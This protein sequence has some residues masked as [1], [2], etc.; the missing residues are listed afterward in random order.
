MKHIQ[1]SYSS[2]DKQK[3]RV[4]IS[5]I[6]LLVL[7]ILLVFWNINAGSVPLSLSE[8]LGILLGNEEN[9]VACHIVWD[10]RLPRLLSAMLLGG[11]LS[12]SGFL[13]QTFLQ[14]RLPDRLFLEF[15]PGRRWLSPL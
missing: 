10:I 7:L 2:E 11:I 8:I 15:L 13:L 14:T 9:E 5:Y 1:A 6:S 4:Q 3:L 12:V